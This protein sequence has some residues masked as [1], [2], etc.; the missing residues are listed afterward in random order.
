MYRATLRVL[1]L[2]VAAATGV[3]L[4][5][6]AGSHKVQQGAATTPVVT[7]PAPAYDQGPQ[8]GVTITIVPAVRA[9]QRLAQRNSTAAPPQ[10][11]GEQVSRPDLLTEAV[12]LALGPRQPRMVSVPPRSTPEPPTTLALE[13]V[14]R[15]VT[16]FDPS[17]Y[18]DARPQS[19]M[20]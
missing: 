18:P 14:S 7:T 5:G 4:V 2:A 19:I 17:R 3:F 1:A 9:E 8:G 6:C 20:R 10:D 12:L 15:A 16:Y 13:Q 11:P